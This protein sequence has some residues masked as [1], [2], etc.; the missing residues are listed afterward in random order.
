MRSPTTWS[1][2]PGVGKRSKQRTGKPRVAKPR[3]AAPPTLPAE[4]V[5]SVRPGEAM[6]A[7]KLPQRHL[8]HQMLWPARWI[9]DGRRRGVDAQG[10]I[11]S[12]NDLCGIDRPR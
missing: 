5:T 1:S 2:K 8:I 12:G 7:N 9:D 11:D 6:L 4:P 3:T 10:V